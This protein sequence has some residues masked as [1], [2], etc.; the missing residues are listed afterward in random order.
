MCWS[1]FFPHFF[2]YTGH[3][4]HWSGR[5]S[6]TEI[7]NAQKLW[8]LF[9]PRHRLWSPGGRS[10]RQPHPHRQLWVSHSLSHTNPSRFKLMCV[11]NN[12]PPVCGL[13]P[14]QWTILFKRFSC[15]PHIINHTIKKGTMES[16]L[17]ESFQGGKIHFNFS[18]FIC[19]FNAIP[20]TLPNLILSR[21]LSGK[22]LEQGCLGFKI[23]LTSK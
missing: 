11:K 4:H 14:S 8:S 5:Y 1:L 18:Q 10:E 3:I 13:S 2:W 22:S 20:A 12:L 7:C 16:A 23:G 15:S 19:Y 9:V 17:M 21:T 6:D